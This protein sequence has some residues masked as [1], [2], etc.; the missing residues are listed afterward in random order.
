MD[1]VSRQLWARSSRSTGVPLLALIVILGV[2]GFVLTSTTIRRDRDRA[3]ERHA[4]V[5]AVQA[6]EVLGRAG[7]YLAGP[8][9]RVARRG[10]ARSARWA[11]ATSASGGLNDVLWF[12]SAPS[13][14]RALYERLRGVP[15]SR[16]T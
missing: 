6:Q 13:S 10:Q 1:G 15:I 7:A 12:Q 9:V 3:A 4:E 16:L 14:G 2:G 5:Q 11:Q 8:A